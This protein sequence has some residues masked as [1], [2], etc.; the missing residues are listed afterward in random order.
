MRI[1]DWSSDVCSSDLQPGDVGAVHVKGDQPVA[2]I[3]AVRRIV[4]LVLVPHVDDAVALAALI[5]HYAHL[6]GDAAA[7][8][9]VLLVGVLLARDS[10]EHGEAAPGIDLRAPHN[11]PNGQA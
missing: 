8:A 3:G 7:G 9:E 6:H 1:S 5:D 4:A 2:V 11:A 10:D